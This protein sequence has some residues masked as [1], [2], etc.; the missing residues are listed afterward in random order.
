M[1]PL[2]IKL[3]GL[4]RVVRPRMRAPSARFARIAHVWTEASAFLGLAISS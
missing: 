3:A 1:S 4:G 2:R